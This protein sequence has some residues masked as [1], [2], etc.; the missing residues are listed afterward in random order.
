MSTCYTGTNLPLELE[1]E[2]CNGEYTLT[3]CIVNSAAIPYLNL[4]ANSQLNTIISNLILA[5]Q[6]KDEQIAILTAQIVA[7]DNRI[8]EL[9]TP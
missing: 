1:T 7:L 2:P 3:N 5:M 6:Y 4:P 8:T 9:E